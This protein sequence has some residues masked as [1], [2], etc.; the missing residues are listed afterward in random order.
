MPQK[1]SR[2]QTTDFF[3]VV[4]SHSAIMFV[5]AHPDDEQV[6]GP[7]LA[8]CADTCRDVVVVLLTRGQS[9]W[10]LAAADNNRTLAQVRERELAR[11]TRILGCVPVTLDYV[12]GVS[13]AH[14]GGLAVHDPA[15]Q[16][17]NRWEAHHK[18]QIAPAMHY[19]Q[20]TS[21]AGDPAEALLALYRTKRPT[22]L[23]AFEPENGFTGH[24]EHI[25]ATMAAERALET[26]NRQAVPGVPLYYA[27]PNDEPV[28]GAQTI[29]AADL[30]KRGGRDYRPVAWE[31]WNCYE[32]QYGPNDGSQ[33]RDAGMKDRVEKCQLRACP[34]PPPA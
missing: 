2:T 21:E 5:G 8:Y 23:I 27:W 1:E 25:A 26:Y 9:G 14:P 24:P 28:D 7:L 4:S 12:N 18:K 16:A 20:W 33:K 11:A 22:A 19:E 34:A 17:V 3:N 29:T 10:N 13:R 15:E 32:S 6:I 31:S 30:E